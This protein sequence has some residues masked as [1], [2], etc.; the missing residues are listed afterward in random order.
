VYRVETDQDALPEVEALPRAALSR[1]AEVLSLLEIAPW[2][3]DSY[4]LARPDG[5]MRTI[6]FGEDVQG[7]VVYLVLEDQRRVVVLRVLWLT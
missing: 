7:L 3:G 6:T 5:A 1:Y 4:N 2:S